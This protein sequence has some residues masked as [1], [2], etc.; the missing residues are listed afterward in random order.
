MPTTPNGERGRP[1]QRIIGTIH[2]LLFP[3]D[4]VAVKEG[5]LPKEYHTHQLAFETRQEYHQRLAKMES[6][7]RV[8]VLCSEMDIR[9]TPSSQSTISS[10]ENTDN[11]SVGIVLIER[12]NSLP[13]PSPSQSTDTTNSGSSD[14]ETNSG[15][16]QNNNPR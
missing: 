13:V 5:S 8:E 3:Q 10:N 9:T 11:E 1:Q 16:Q 4:K 6:L 7:H 12:L 14:S 15:S 2:N